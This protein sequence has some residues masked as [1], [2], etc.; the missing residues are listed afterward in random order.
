MLNL[1]EIRAHVLALRQRGVK[2]T[3]HR[4]MLAFLLDH[5]DACE[6]ALRERRGPDHPGLSAARISKLRA[7]VVRHG[8]DGLYLCLRPGEA[9]ALLEAAA[10]PAALA[11]RPSAPKENLETAAQ[12]MR[13]V[14]RPIYDYADLTTGERAAVKGAMDAYDA[15]V[16]A[17]PSAPPDVL[18]RC[19]ARVLDDSGD[20]AGV[21]LNDVYGWLKD[22][23]AAL[24]SAPAVQECECDP[25]RVMDYPCPRHGVPHTSFPCPDSERAHEAT[26]PLRAARPSAPP[27]PGEPTWEQAREAA[28]RVVEDREAR[29]FYMRAPDEIRSTIAAAIRALARPTPQGGDAPSSDTRSQDPRPSRSG[30]SDAAPSSSTP[31]GGARPTPAERAQNAKCPPHAYPWPGRV[32]AKCRDCGHYRPEGDATQGEGRHAV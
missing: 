16:R 7:I 13:T 5:I 8:V 1:D 32:G 6:A 17:R 21:V 11:A 19:I 26:C 12:R 15:V 9:A 30:A 14:L 18:D 27:A 28:A 23:R 29:F 2:M 3:G 10:H 20:D 4:A 31:D 25:D 22:A 24:P